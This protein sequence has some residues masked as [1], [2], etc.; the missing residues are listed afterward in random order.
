MKIVQNFFRFSLLTRFSL[1][2]LLSHNHIAQTES[3]IILLIQ[4]FSPVFYLI[5]KLTN[6]L[7]I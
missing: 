5:Y 7:Y 1:S 3:I 2:Y 6:S 4:L